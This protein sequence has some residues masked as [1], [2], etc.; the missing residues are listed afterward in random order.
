MTEVS[1]V[2]CSATT[3]TGKR[4]SRTTCKYFKF[5]YQHAKSILGLQIKKSTIPNTGQGLFTLKEI[6]KNEDITEYNGVK[7]TVE[8]A[9]RKEES[10]YALLINKDTV[11]DGKSTQSCLG[12]YANMCR[13]LNKP[14][15]KGNNAR[16]VINQKTKKVVLRATKKIKI[17]EEIFVSYGRSYWK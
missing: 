12:R 15:C 13:S 16:F 7:M 8:E 6:K 9:N 14:H 3:K 11:I 5:C 4:C 10:G 17:G 2:K 1:C